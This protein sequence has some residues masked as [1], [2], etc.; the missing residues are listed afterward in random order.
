[1]KRKK[2]EKSFYYNPGSH[3]FDRKNKKYIDYIDYIVIGAGT[4]GGVIAKK[5]TDNMSTSVLVLEAGTNMINEL[6]DPSRTGSAL[7]ASDNRHSFNIFTKT[8]LNIGR[9]LR[10]SGGRAIGGSSEH[11]AMYAV[12][13]SSNLYDEW[14]KLV[15]P[16]WSYN[17]ILSLFKEN[18][19]YTGNTQEPNARGT[20]GPIFVRQQIIPDG[21]LIETLA[22]A[23]SDTLGI[24]IV[25]DYNTGIRDCTFFRSQFMHK[26]VN[27]KFIR[28]STATGYLNENIVKQGN[29]FRPDEFGI[30]KRKLSILAKTTVNKIL[31]QKRKG[32][33]IAVGVEFV[34]NGVSERALARKGVI[35]SAG[36]FSS[37]IL[38]RS[39]IGRSTDLAKAGI[40]TLV[41]SPN[42]GHN[43]QSHFFVGIGIEVETQRLLDVI[44]ADPDQPFPSGAF[45]GEDGEGRRLQ[46]F[47]SPQPSFVPNQVVFINNWGFDRAKRS[48]IMSIGIGDVNPK[49][50]GTIMVAHSDPEAYPSV[51]FNPLDNPDDLNFVVD[52][53]I[54]TFNIMKRAREIDPGGI[55]KVVYPPENIFELTNE[56]EKRSQL[57]DYAKS[58]YTNFA[59]FAGQCKMGR[60]IQEGVVDGFLNVFGT[61]NLKVADLSISP[62]IP[63]GN[64]SIPAQMIGLNTVRFIL[65][66]S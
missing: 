14:A 29:E 56:Q 3:Y 20:H 16:Q 12:R 1:M 42:V 5:L 2:E 19:T 43:F 25:E 9:Q 50:R 48:N 36:N 34:R 37:V 27:G 44:D 30:N 54:E 15:G 63:D 4:A 59:H 11:N 18:E 53:Y 35:V 47:T 64:T 21:G 46:L 58:S 52:Q 49:S 24:P 8:E 31:F 26:E 62:I 33:H 55:Y 39:G 38:Q 57:A 28:S 60:N 61:Q 51:S 65:E 40:S 7:L 45:K 13:G 23:T 66:G 17:N 32:V 6:S 22:K 41:E 10:L